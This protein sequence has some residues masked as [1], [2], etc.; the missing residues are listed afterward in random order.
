MKTGKALGI[1]ALVA[2]LSAG[3]APGSPPGTGSPGTAS[4]MPMGT[5]SP[6][7][8]PGMM[9][10]SGPAA[11][12]AVITIS[13]FA[14]QTPASVPAGATVTVTNKDTV[15]HTVTADTGS[16]FNVEVKANGGTATFTA[17]SKAG[18]YPFHCSIH[19]QML[20]TLTVK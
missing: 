1:L 7:S 8:S 9:E 12:A 14:F 5:S 13:D 2:L 20:G 4:S 18:S 3:C 19:P 17:P 11:A 15:E 10:G 16:A 6:M